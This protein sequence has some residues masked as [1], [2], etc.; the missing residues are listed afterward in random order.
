MFKSRRRKKYENLKDLYQTLDGSE[1]GLERQSIE[2]GNDLLQGDQTREKYAADG[3]EAKNMENKDQ[4]AKDKVNSRKEYEEDAYFKEMTPAFENDEEESHRKTGSDKSSQLRD[5]EKEKTSRTSTR[6]H[7]KDD[8]NKDKTQEEFE[9]EEIYNYSDFESE[10][11]GESLRTDSSMSERDQTVEEE[12]EYINEGQQDVDIKEENVSDL[13]KDEEEPERSNSSIS[14]SDR[15]DEQKMTEPDSNDRIAEQ[16]NDI[17]LEEYE[18]WESVQSTS[19]I[20]KKFENSEDLKETNADENNENVEEAENSNNIETEHTELIQALQQNTSSKIKDINANDINHEEQDSTKVET[21]NFS[22]E[23]RNEIRSW[24]EMPEDNFET[25]WQNCDPDEYWETK[26]A[27]TS[28]LRRARKERKELQKNSKLQERFLLNGLDSDLDEFCEQPLVYENTIGVDSDVRNLLQA[29]RQ[30]K[31]K[32]QN[33]VTR[34]NNYSRIPYFRGHQPALRTQ[35]I[36]R[37][38]QPDNSDWFAHKDWQKK[39]TGDLQKQNQRSNDEQRTN[40]KKET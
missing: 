20:G 9:L 17:I 14:Y 12:E 10:N 11:Q 40:D 32:E 3:E 38:R 19:P 13:E 28:A 36:Y 39:D 15:K 8:E 26:A 4:S 31:K 35:P 18:E 21:T 1:D 23:D 24:R 27:R 22:M 25:N 29:E 16:E 33:V 5:T 37:S 30:F 7:A 2:E 34:S 6:N